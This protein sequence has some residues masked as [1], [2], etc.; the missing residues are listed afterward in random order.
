MEDEGRVQTTFRVW[1]PNAQSVSVIGDFNSWDET[2][3][4]MEKIGTGVWEASVP[5]GLEEYGRYQYCVTCADRHQVHKSDPYAYF[6]DTRPGT[7]SRYYD[8]EGY[9]WHDTS[10]QHHKEQEPHYENPVNI[11]EVHLGSWRRY[12][13]GNVFNYDK[14]AEELVP[15]VKEMGYTHIEIDRKSV[16]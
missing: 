2:K 11:Y 5:F 1:A 16:V 13:D 10:W 15:Y 6:F 9:Q 7:A 14:L 3:T 8:I 12:P 4:P